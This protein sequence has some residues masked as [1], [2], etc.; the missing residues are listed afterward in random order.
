MLPET[1][2]RFPPLSGVPVQRS[3]GPPQSAAL[4]ERQDGTRGRLT[5]L[6][7][8]DGRFVILNPD[9]EWGNRQARPFVLGAWPSVLIAL[10]RPREPFTGAG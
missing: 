4:P 9:K 7:G 5:V 2:S 8:M 6:Y 3:V 10:P 1:P